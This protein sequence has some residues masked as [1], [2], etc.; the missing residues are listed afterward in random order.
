MLSCTPPVVSCL[1]AVLCEC[2]FFLHFLFFLLT[3]D[4]LYRL[5]NAFVHPTCCIN[6]SLLDT[7]ISI[8]DK[9]ISVLD[10]NIF[11]LNTGC[12]VPL[13][14]MLASLIQDVSAACQ[15]TNLNGCSV[16]LFH[17]PNMFFDA[18]ETYPLLYDVVFPCHVYKGLHAIVVFLYQEIYVIACNFVHLFQSH[19]CTIVYFHYC[20][21]FLSTV[22]MY[23]DPRQDLHV[24]SY[25]AFMSAV[26]N[27]M[28][29]HDFL[30][31][32]MCFFSMTVSLSSTLTQCLYDAGCQG[33]QV[34]VIYHM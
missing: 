24:L 25:L 1:E 20:Q 18:P 8:L 13:Q 22:Y 33:A 26:R 19:Y 10:K 31:C 34:E 4:L 29:R 15:Y 12:G 14:P 21:L 11:L 3:P 27:I 9:N 6:V 28:L 32:I 7:Y 17:D 5:M 2:I 16:D 23:C 30:A